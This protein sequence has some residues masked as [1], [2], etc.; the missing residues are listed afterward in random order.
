MDKNVKLGLIGRKRKK[1]TNKNN[2]EN[3]NEKD[4]KDKDT[5]QNEDEPT[6]EAPKILCQICKKEEYKYNCPRCS[7]KTCSV[8]C[9]K[10][11]KNKYGCDGE[12]D[13]FKLVAKQDDYNEQV[14]HRD[15]NFLNNAIKDINISNKKIYYL[16]EDLNTAQAKTFKTFKRILKKFRD[17]NYF[18]SPLIMECN[19]INKSYSDPAQKKIFWT[20]KLNF[21][22]DK[23]TYI[24]DNVFDG[25]ETNINQLID[26]LNKN[27]QSVDKNNV[28]LLN[29]IKNKEWS[30]N[31]GFYLKMDIFGLSLD[32]KKN[33][34]NYNKYYYF[35]CK[36]DTP[37]NELLRGKSVYE[38]PEFY[39]IKKE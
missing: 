21:L 28:G 30:N 5:E 38:Y 12:K 22:D 32:E 2:K 8:K 24:F 37:I 4:K 14:F 11:H 1:Q 7:L 25:D 23:F 27:K 26:Y 13:K 20:I 39:L 15:V 6:E 33:Y 19:K 35:C 18:K 9:V 10:F 29:I 36:L 16:T 34:F 17:I 31:Y 3:D